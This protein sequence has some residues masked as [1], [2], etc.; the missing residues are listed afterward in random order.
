[1][2]AVVA[3]QGLLVEMEGMH[4]PACIGLGP[5]D[6]EA[7]RVPVTVYP[8][9]GPF[10]GAAIDFTISIPAGYPHSPPKAHIHQTVHVGGMGECSA[11]AV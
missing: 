5:V 7:M 8:D 6:W 9:E 1:M 11:C 10:A 2:D 3:L 4:L